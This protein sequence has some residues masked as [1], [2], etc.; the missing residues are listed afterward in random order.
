M[1][2][3]Y[4]EVEYVEIPLE[5]RKK[6]DN[7]KLF[8][9]MKLASSALVFGLVA[10]T[11]FQGFNYAT[12]RLLP[13]TTVAS[14]AH[15]VTSGSDKGVIT[16]TGTD[17]SNLSTNSNETST[18][19]SSVVA[20]VMPS[21]VSVSV[22]EQQ[23]VSD[24]FGRTYS[25]EA[26]G[27]GSGIIIGQNDKQVLIATNNHVVEGA[28]SVSITF[29]NSKTAKATVKG[30]DSAADLAVVAVDLSQLSD[31]TKSVIKVATLGDSSKTKVGEMAIAIGNALGY[32]Q[33][34]TVGYISALD[35]EIT[36]EDN[37]MK[38]IQT[39]AAINPGNSGGAL[40]N[41]AGEVIGIN[42]A[43]YAAEEVEGMG[44]AIP[45]SKAIPII[46]ELMNK[47]TVPESEQAYLGIKGQDVTAEYAKGFGM[48]EGV[49]IGEVTKQSPASDAG[50]VSGDIITKFDG[51]DATTMERLQEL[52]A[53][54]KAGTKVAIT[55]QVLDNG[56]YV[57]KTVNVILG[58]KTSTNS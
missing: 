4:E 8:S 9:F 28:D 10:G 57:E 11:A 41:A 52:L 18:D 45:I 24:I 3:E 47:V 42:S 26:T 15:V 17:S 30:T 27:S 16:N 19:V 36:A 13:E 5:E 37:T 6:K 20:N 51:K 14:T 12:A 22:T 21:I 53:G 35:R 39:D 34:V 25:N 7:P 29:V 58:S 1:N 46:T 49:Y 32:G 44:Y 54:T 2:N 50:L 48:P 38:L 56:K 33:S 23:K 40:L 43:K 55:Y 31:S